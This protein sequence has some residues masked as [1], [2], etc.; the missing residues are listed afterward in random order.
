KETVHYSRQI[1]MACPHRRRGA[2]WA[3]MVLHDTQVVFAIPHPHL[4]AAVCHHGYRSVFKLEVRRAWCNG[5]NRIVV[6]ERQVPAELALFLNGENILQLLVLSH[7]S[8]HI[9]RMKRLFPK[10][11]IVI[12]D[13]SAQE[14]VARFD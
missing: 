8:M 12:I 11:S 7:G 6:T 14:L 2:A 9:H 1:L 3:T 13:K 4:A 5:I 10:T